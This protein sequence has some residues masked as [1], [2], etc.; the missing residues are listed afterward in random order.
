MSFARYRRLLTDPEPVDLYAKRVTRGGGEE[1]ARG[2]YVLYWMQSARRLRRNPALDY[3]IERANAAGLPVVVYE[4]IRPDY[5]SANDRIHTFVLQGVRANAAGAAARGLRYHF[6]LP[7]TAGEARGVVRKLSERARLV[8]TDEFPTFVVREHARRF[9]ATAPVAVHLF[10]GNGILPMRAFAAEQ[11]S[12]KVLRDRARK[13]FPEYWAPF[14]DVAPR[15]QFKGS[16]DLPSYDGLDPERAAASCAIEHSVAPA[17]A[18]GGRDHALRLLQHFVSE[19][20]DGYAE[21]RN[22]DNA[23]TSGLSPYLHFGHLGAHELAE[24]VLLS[25][26]PEA[27]VDAFIESLVI[28][29]ELSFNMCFYHEDHATLGALPEWAKRTLDKHRGD[30][31][32]PVYSYEELAQA[33]THDR[34]W[35]L[36]QRALLA[37]GTMHGYLRMLW[38]KKIIEWSETPEHAHAAMVRLFETYALDGRDPNTHAG[39]LWCFGKH[40]RPW[41]PERPIF[42]TVRYMSTEAAGRKKMRLDDYEREVRTCEATARNRE[43]S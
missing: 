7:R 24:A 2:E 14:A 19:R 33:N 11:Y 26:A 4:S 22:L 32:S 34:L 43:G 35:N 17:P 10:D 3:A 15:R 40:D 39:I 31:R 36:A 23:Y 9:V 38:G 18:A 30:R 12:A 41:G 21:R 1:N 25:G 42:G 29:R 16:I 6:F 20:L 8:V 28:R 27:D 13:M 5:P 37:C